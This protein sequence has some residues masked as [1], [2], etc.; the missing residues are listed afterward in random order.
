[1]SGWLCVGLRPRQKLKIGENITIVVNRFSRNQ[2]EVAVHAPK[3]LRVER[4]PI[5]PQ[6]PKK[7]HEK[8]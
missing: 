1:M 4:Q 2:Y 8:V 5:P 6:P 3:E 7:P